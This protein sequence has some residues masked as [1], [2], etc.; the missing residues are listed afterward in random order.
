M[1]KSTALPLQ[2]LE[3]YLELLIADNAP[4]VLL[5]EIGHGRI[6]APYL[7]AVVGLR[8]LVRERS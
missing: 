4:Q 6:N 8:P 2:G 5:P 3:F 1:F 7:Q